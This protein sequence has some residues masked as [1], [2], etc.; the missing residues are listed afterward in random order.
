MVQRDELQCSSGGRV[1]SEKSGAKTESGK[2][3]STASCGEFDPELL[4]FPL[5][6][7][8]RERTA[9][10]RVDRGRCTAKNVTIRQISP[11]IWCSLCAHTYIHTF[12]LPNEMQTMPHPDP[13]PPPLR[14]FSPL[15]PISSLSLPAAKCT[16]GIIHRIIQ[17]SSCHSCMNR[18]IMRGK[19]VSHFLPLTSASQ[20]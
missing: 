10:R 18:H 11:A 15:C 8:K 7:C 20:I 1:R 12:R 6:A 5:Q 2:R 19:E 4:L 17:S 3:N 9:G 16:A 13:R 14:L